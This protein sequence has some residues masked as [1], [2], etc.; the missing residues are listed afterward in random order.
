MLGHK[1]HFVKVFTA[2]RHHHST[3]IYPLPSIPLIP[4]TA[5]KCFLANDDYCWSYSSWSSRVNLR[6]ES[7]SGL[8]CVCVFVSLTLRGASPSPN[9]SSSSRLRGHL[10]RAPWKPNK[11]CWP[12]GPLGERLYEC[13]LTLRV[14]VGRCPLSGQHV[15]YRQ[16]PGKHLAG[17]SPLLGCYYL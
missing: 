6:L 17:I 14:T 3:N 9:K 13:V 11:S 10:E 2:D 4:C 12:A 8:C 7:S 16:L 1:P 5:Q 15:K